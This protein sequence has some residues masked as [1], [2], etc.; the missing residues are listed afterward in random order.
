MDY[1]I[2]NVT[3][4]F[5]ENLYSCINMFYGRNN[6]I[7][8]D[9][10]NFDASSVKTINSMFRECTNLKKIEFGKIKTNAVNDI[11]YSFYDCKSL[12]YIDLSNF[13]T[14]SVTKMLYVFNECEK[15]IY[16]DLSSFDTSN[17]ED[18]EGLFYRCHNLVSVNVLSFVTSKVTNM[19]N[20]FAYC[21]NIRYIDLHNF[22]GDVVTKMNHMFFDCLKLK[23][24]NLL[25]FE[26][27]K[28]TYIGNYN[29]GWMDYY[30]PSNSYKY[31][32]NDYK[33]E[34]NLNNG[35]KDCTDSC[36]KDKYKF[37]METN[38]C[39][40]S[41]SNFEYNN[42]CY[43]ECPENT[44][45]FIT[46]KC[47]DILP[48]NYYLDKSDNIYKEC[49]EL[50]KKCHQ[51]GTATNH[52]C[53]EC[54]NGYTFVDESS[55]DEHN[56]Y[57]ECGTFYYYLDGDNNYSC[58]QNCPTKYNILIT[59]KNKCIDQCKND[60]KYKYEYNNDC[61]IQCPSSTLTD[62][63]NNKCL[64]SCDDKFEYNNKCYS[65]CPS[66]TSKAITDKRVCLATIP[67]DYYFDN[68]DGIH[69]K[70]HKN[71]I[72]CKGAGTDKD[73]NCEKCNS[74]Y[75]L[76]NEADRKFTCLECGYYYYYD[77]SK[78]DYSCT[79]SSDC[80]NN[81][82][83]LITAKN[84]CIDE[85][86][87]DNIYKY[88]HNSDC[89]KEC[90][91]PYKTDVDEYKCLESCYDYKFEYD[92][93]CYTNCPDGTKKAITEKRR[94]CLITIPDNYY[95]DI[96]DIYK[97]CHKNCVKCY[98]AGTDKDNNCKECKTNYI[99][100]N[101][102][103][104]KYTCF[105][106]GNYYYYDSSNNDYLCTSSLDCPKYSKYLISEKKKCIDDCKK[107][108][109]YIYENNNNCLESCPSNTNT[110]IDVDEKKCLQSCY[111]HKFEYNDECY[112][113]CPGKSHRAL[114]SRRVCLDNLQE[115]YYLDKNDNIYKP[116]HENCKT[117]YGAG[118]DRNNNCK[119]CYSNYIFINETEQ[120]N[121][122]FKCKYYYYYDS[123]NNDYSCTQSS[124][125][126]ENHKNFVSEK[127]KCIDECK[128]DDTYKFDNNKNCLI[129][130]P[131]NMKTD[132]EEYKCLQSCDN[133]FEYNNTC[134][135]DCSNNT[136]RVFIDKRIC[137]DNIT[138]N[139]YLDENDNIYKQCHEN[140]KTCYGNGTD[141]NNNC[142]ECYSNYI[143][144]NETDQI[145]TCFKCE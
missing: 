44:Y 8:I 108:Q 15:L 56:C 52:N 64:Q 6:I 21:E 99:L 39:V 66:G 112:F 58:T 37:N 68:S 106:C 101:E 110:K 59:A 41:C 62:A 119:E 4:I 27:K 134:L 126:P 124:V 96:D 90:P 79:S 139:Y 73:N 43:N 72:T 78:N 132:F 98:G 46:K 35:I 40:E 53:D 51:S 81:C 104:R 17:V 42:L 102:V 113:D 60:N 47:S 127:N 57:Q 142:K 28:I 9:L 88:E 34:D 89:V 130:C 91:S 115:N 122:C 33:L 36:F 7:E 30:V 26:G 55:I 20:M 1:Y 116:C 31:C 123:S 32:T 93:K 131:N 87:K 137:L 95:K 48:E 82:N 120:I 92:N 49:Y 71:C 74:G 94:E 22:S 85:C 128:N 38:S 129:E 83:I 136:Y 23:F 125:C 77:I 54:K 63:D 84:K 145:N 45:P 2:N 138:E 16:I 143:F 18:M 50:C 133:K 76:M 117:C 100:M 140:C 65:N 86:K 5:N 97:L 70:C 3:L 67:G 24:V 75:I 135:S 103:D 105:E 109:T 61:L 107:D 12:I 141:K 69:K 25:N 10:S 13:V 14:S 19:G 144:I 121:T 111:E 11:S 118:N 114:Q 29:M 80:P